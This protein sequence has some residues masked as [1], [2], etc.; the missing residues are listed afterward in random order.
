MKVSSKMDENNGAFEIDPLAKQENQV[1]EKTDPT[2]VLQKLRL[3]EATLI[4]EKQN[5]LTLRESLQTRVKEEIEVR[6]NNSEKL[7]SEIANLKLFCEEM[8][9]TL[10]EGLLEK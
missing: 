3:D 8:T 10:N 7:K 2:A 6:R 4:E 5:W 1:G 9:K